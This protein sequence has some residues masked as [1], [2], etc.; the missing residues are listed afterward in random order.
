M[1]RTESN[2]HNPS[3][4]FEDLFDDKERDVPV[5]SHPV[6]D[7]WPG[8]G[9]ESKPDSNDTRKQP[10]Q[11]EIQT[12]GE[13]YI[14]SL[15]KRLK[16]VKSPKISCTSSS[17]DMS[18]GTPVLQMPSTSSADSD[19]EDGHCLSEQH[20]EPEAPI[21]A[22]E[23]TCLLYDARQ[24]QKEHERLM[25]EDR[26][27]QAVQEHFAPPHSRE[28]SGSARSSL[29]QSSR[30]SSI[31]ST[32]ARP[33]I[34]PILEQT[35]PQQASSSRIHFSD[36]VRIS[37]GIKSKRD[38][39]RVS[40]SNVFV[41]AAS[42]AYGT[43]D[44]NG[45]AAA[46]TSNL[47]YSPPPAI[48]G[49]GVRTPR[50]SFSRSSVSG[51]MSRAASFLSEDGTTTGR[52]RASTPASIYAP[53]LLPSKTAPSPSRHFYLTFKRDDGQVT[54]RE[55]VRQQNA[56]KNKAK[57]RRGRT[58]RQGS[59]ASELGSGEDDESDEDSDN[60]DQFGHGWY[61]GLAFWTCGISRLFRR[62]RAGY[63][64]RS[65]DPKTAQTDAEGGAADH[66]NGTSSPSRRNSDDDEEQ[67]TTPLRE[68]K[69]EMEVLFGSKPWRYTKVHYWLHRLRELRSHSRDDPDLD[70]EW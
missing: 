59:L 39:R 9:V 49:N 23:T 14:E 64:P 16:A 40:A 10:I 17:R 66:V 68:H 42:N 11:W 41:P 57:R 33:S 8:T 12:E 29:G 35:T 70:E 36:S 32:P 28:R 69:S 34:Q 47:D 52:S 56:R 58:R 55:L 21:V 51:R 5:H 46:S 48:L 6:P 4:S 43:F 67:S 27:K 3:P 31:D 18:S 19:S 30:R 65:V 7:E 1:P 2:G 63:T 15:E 45:N 53:L 38:K 44:T 61:C 37:G 60:E 26:N 54:Y 50:G 20:Q 22:S 13:A 62:R 25:R 24:Q